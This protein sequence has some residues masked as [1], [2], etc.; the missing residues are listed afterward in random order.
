M[1]PNRAFDT[2]VDDIV[3][4]VSVLEFIIAGANLGLRKSGS[5]PRRS[6]RWSEGPQAVR[7]GRAAGG[8][9]DQDCCR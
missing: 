9:E 1:V 4:W 6:A 2:R 5:R 7:G 8:S 3:I